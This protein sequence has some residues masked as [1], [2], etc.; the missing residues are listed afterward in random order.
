M[1]VTLCLTEHY[2][3]LQPDIAVLRQKINKQWTPTTNITWQPV[4]D[5][6]V[7][8]DWQK[9][10]LATLVAPFVHTNYTNV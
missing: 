2:M 3:E 7:Q 10:P 4:S 6:A 8:R 1:T 5:T 9:L